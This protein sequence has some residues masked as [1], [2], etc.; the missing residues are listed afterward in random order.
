MKIKQ[1]LSDGDE[2]AFAQ[3]VFLGMSDSIF[4]HL[5][6]QVSYNPRQLF[7]FTEN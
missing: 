2:T 7:D 6:K 5:K 1:A 4:K 3:S